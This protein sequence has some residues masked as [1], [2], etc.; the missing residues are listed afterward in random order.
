MRYVLCIILLFFGENR[1]IPI[2]SQSIVHFI[3][4]LGID[5]LLPQK[6]THRNK[7]VRSVLG[8]VVLIKGD[9]ISNR[10]VV[11]WLCDT[12]LPCTGRSI[13]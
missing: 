2:K 13:S 6:C 11:H 9:Q 7:K 12:H 5:D 1:T 8:F 10:S 4:L 3:A